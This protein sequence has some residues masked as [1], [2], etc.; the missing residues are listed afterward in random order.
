MRSADGKPASIELYLATLVGA[1][2]YPLPI[3]WED[4]TAQ[5]NARTVLWDGLLLWQGRDVTHQ[6]VRLVLPPLAA[7][8]LKGDPE[9]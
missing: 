1:G 7:L 8:W 9:Q 3:K 4:D 2:G 6:P 5:T